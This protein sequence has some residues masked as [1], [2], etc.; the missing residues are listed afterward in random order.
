M[1]DPTVSE[2]YVALKNAL[3]AMQDDASAVLSVLSS[4]SDGGAGW[5][6]TAYY[7]LRRALVQGHLQ[8]AEALG[9]LIGS[10]LD[11]QEHGAEDELAENRLH[12]ESMNY[13][14]D[15]IGAILS[16][17]NDTG[18]RHLERLTEAVYC[19]ESLQWVAWL[20]MAKA[21]ADKGDLKRANGAAQAALGLAEELDHLARGNTLLTIG[22]IE[23]LTGEP[24]AALEHLARATAT[25]DEIG[26]SHCK[27]MASLTLA[28]MLFRMKRED[29]AMRA[30]RESAGADADWEEPAVFISERQLVQGAVAEADASV[31]PFLDLEPRSPAVLRQLQL[32]AD[33]KADK[34]P[35]P[36]VAEYLAYK[37]LPPTESDIPH[38]QSLWHEC[39]GFHAAR[40]LL[41]WN[42]LKLNRD[43]EAAREFEAL[44]AQELD[45]EVQ[46]SVLLGL[47]CLASRRFGHRQS[48]ARIRAAA[49]A[50]PRTPTKSSEV[51]RFATITA[52]EPLN[53]GDG[54]DLPE[55]V[56]PPPPVA[57]APP[58]SALPGEAVHLEAVPPPL[59]VPGAAPL[60]GVT[61]PAAAPPTQAGATAHAKPPTGGTRSPKAVFT[62]DLQLF[63]VPDLLEFLKS[64]RRTG[65]LVITTPTGIGAVHM[66]RGMITG[67][68]APDGKNVGD[69]LIESGAI[70]AEQ[71]KAAAEHQKAASPDKLLGSIMIELGLI[72]AETL[73]RV[74]I[75][76]IKQSVFHMVSWT[77]GRFAFEPDKR[78]QVDDVSDVGVALDTQAVLLDVLRELDEQNRDSAGGSD[79][80]EL[81]SGDAI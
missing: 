43:D 30:A 41:A 42:L 29:E 13:L 4:L 46:A 45:P 77:A 69:L 75:T 78:E 58:P 59:P 56:P 20:W 53:L 74:L 26:D 9:R 32:I 24:E 35:L 70:T 19:N 17:D 44:A 1:R 39:E 48:A 66:K 40:E 76:Q 15:G 38:L 71:L 63:A 16:Q 21:A 54:L 60:T 8:E 47:G 57:V 65:T 14:V 36:L 2:S 28:R 62:G 61:G 67:A 72:N 52:G 80:I 79:T 33:V 34:V 37:D 73:Q 81:L 64:S 68:A 11:V 55:V 22:E 7:E 18:I 6:S 5:V 25:F 3:L 27:A 12:R 49:S 10:V 51:P 23:F 50:S 31:R